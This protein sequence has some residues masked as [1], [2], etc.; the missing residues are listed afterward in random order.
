MSKLYKYRSFGV[1]SLREICESEVYFSDPN[2]FNDPLDCSPT[3]I[4]DVSLG[5]LENLCHRMIMINYTKDRADE[6][7]RNY[8]YLSTEHGDYKQDHEV[9]EFYIRMIVDDVKRQLDHMMKNR[10]VL[11]LA[12]QWNSPLMWSHYADEHKGICIEYDISRAVCEKP[13]IVDYK[14]G[15]GICISQIIDLIFNNAETAKKEIEHKYFHTKAGQWGYEEEWRYISDR[16]GTSP[17]PFHLSGIYF[18]MRCDISVVSSIV[19]LLYGAEY[20]VNFYHVH[21][22]QESFDLD[23]R[24]V[25]IENLMACTPRSSA[26]LTFGNIPNE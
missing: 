11:S 8:R 15:R 7:I 14:G 25:E 21:A 16:Q 12:S 17:A 5:D 10:G 13:I 26:L 9:Q 18:G 23:R 3:L 22:N 4:N 6:E 1:N 24:E 20:E 19:K 2:N